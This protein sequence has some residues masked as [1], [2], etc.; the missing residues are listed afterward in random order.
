MFIS[1]EAL[2]LTAEWRG[3]LSSD[4]Y[5]RYLVGFI[6]DEAHCV[7]K[8]YVLFLDLHVTSTIK[9]IFIYGQIAS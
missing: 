8:W 3:M 4:L 1:P 9:L 7:K 2:F 5:R 6:V